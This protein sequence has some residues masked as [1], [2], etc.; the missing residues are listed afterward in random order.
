MPEVTDVW[1]AQV[2]HD[3]VDHRRC[4]PTSPADESEIRSARIRDIGLVPIWVVPRV[5]EPLDDGVGV[6][7]TTGGERDEH[8]DER[9][10]QE[11]DRQQRATHRDVD[12]HPRL[13]G[14][15]RP[16]HVEQRALR[17]PR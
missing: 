7:Q 10:S 17:W 14:L 16:E 1:D 8:H 15:E 11:K 3:L 5:V 6:G 12:D 13:T 4:P 9:L 2:R